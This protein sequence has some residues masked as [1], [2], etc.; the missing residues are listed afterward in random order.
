M[1]K[2]IQMYYDPEDE[3][4][5]T[6]KTA[7]NKT[8]LLEVCYKFAVEFYRQQTRVEDP[9]AEEVI[10]YLIAMLYLLRQGRTIPEILH[11]GRTESANGVSGVK[12][13]REVEE[14]RDVE[15]DKDRS[16]I[17]GMEAG[18]QEI[19]SISVQNVT[20][21]QYRKQMNGGEWRS[22]EGRN[23]G[24]NGGRNDGRIG[25]GEGEREG[26]REGK[27]EDESHGFKSTEGIPAQDNPALA[28]VM[29]DIEIQ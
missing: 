23:G 3:M 14:L 18:R 5:R 15:E 26:E 13:L 19:P 7:R 1:K 9:D 17:D 22:G 16:G 24:R 4:F 8:W 21:Q 25:E 10:Y 12:E 29:A 20:G 28:S 6:L 27:R 2:P 11:D